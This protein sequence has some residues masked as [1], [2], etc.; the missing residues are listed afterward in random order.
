MPKYSVKKQS[1]IIIA[2]TAL[3]NFIRDSAIHD[4]DFENYSNEDSV[5]DSE[6][7]MD[8][9]SVLRDDS[10]MGAFRDSIAIALM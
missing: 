1:K 3:H 5:G 4:A 7:S 2:M 8:D 6:S 10:D 9:S